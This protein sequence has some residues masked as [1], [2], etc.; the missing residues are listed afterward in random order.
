MPFIGLGLHFLVAIFFAVHVI[1]K[2][3]QMYWLI[4][5]FSFPLLGSLVYFLVEFLPASRV[6]R[7]LKS[8]AA[9]ALKVLDPTRELRAARDAFDLTPTAQNQIRLA[10]ALLDAGEPAKAVEQFDLCLKGPFAKDPE[11][12]F[13][14]AKARL[15][16]NQPSDAVRLLHGIR[17]RNKSFRQEQLAVL[18]AQA[19][20]AE[21]SNIPAREEFEIAVTRFGGIESKAEYAIWAAKVGDLETANRLQNDL[22]QTWKHWDA[23]VR[24]LQG[25]LFKRVDAAIASAQR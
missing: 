10:N 9:M 2:G 6:D 7:G 14:A 19:H 12:G 15:L 3:R 17:E 23:H 20:A 21:G 4:I 22:R 1:R 13:C 24:S 5:L 18:L 25:P 11:I 8:A 16:A